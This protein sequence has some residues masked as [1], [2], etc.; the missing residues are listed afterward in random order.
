MARQIA[1]TARSL[2]ALKPEAAAY[3]VREVGRTGLRLRVGPS[4]SKSF[5]WHHSAAGRVYTLGSFGDGTNGT[6]TLA[7]ARTKLEEY[8]AK[9]KVGVDPEGTVEGKKRPQTVEDLCGVFYEECIKLRRKRP[10]EAKAVLDQKIV[11]IL[12]RLPLLAVDT[13]QARRPVVAMVKAGH[14]VRAGKVLQVLKQLF[15]FAA[16]NGFMPANPAAPLR[17]DDL[18]VERNRGD[19]HLSA[20]E[21]PVVLKAIEAS[22]MEQAVRLGLLFLFFSGLRT[23]EALTLRWDDVDFDDA[24]V[25]V[26][27]EN[28]KLTL[29][30]ARSAKPF[31]QP[32]S[33]RAVAVLRELEARCA[34][35]AKLYHWAEP[36]PWVFA[37]PSAEAGHLGDKAL[38]RAFRRLWKP[39]RKAGQALPKPALTIPQASPHNFRD[40]LA[41]H[42]SDTLGIAPH[43][44]QLCLGHSLNALLR[45]SVAAKYDHSSRI[46]EKRQALEAYAVWVEG[47]LTGKTAE[48][49]PFPAGGD[50]RAAQ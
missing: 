49:V 24:T 9:A 1:F 18:G 40:T 38:G 6:L 50:V 19:R 32:L 42:M 36:S 43:V 4:G 5:R 12:G 21:I 37:S 10:E 45:N 28:M 39:E 15:N 23:L 11:P 47:L 33:T 17:A 22:N 41:T 35:L 26:R 14:P 34:K 8:R 46:G 25:T 44:P 27:V 48:V 2:E 29:K 7:A 20:E 31:I 16:A 30:Q 13:V 3:E